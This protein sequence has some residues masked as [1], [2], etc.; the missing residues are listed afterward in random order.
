[1]RPSFMRCMIFVSLDVD[2]CSLVLLFWWWLAVG[3]GSGLVSERGVVVGMVVGSGG[4]L[5]IDK[6]ASSNSLVRGSR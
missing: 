5:L 2:G 4:S 3:S 1:M 6:T